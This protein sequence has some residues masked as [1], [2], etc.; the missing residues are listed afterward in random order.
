M[1]KRVDVELK[2]VQNQEVME[3][4]FCL[5]RVCHA[6][7]YFLAQAHDRRCIPMVP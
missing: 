7:S 5:E 3:L 6:P 1:C 2:E 4:G